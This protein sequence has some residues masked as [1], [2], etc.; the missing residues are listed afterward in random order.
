MFSLYVLLLLSETPLGRFSNFLC[1][2]VSNLLF[3]ILHCGK[4]FQLYPI[5]FLFLFQDQR[6]FFFFE[7]T[8]HGYSP[9]CFMNVTF[10]YASEMINSKICL[11]LS[12]ALCN[13]HFS[14]FLTFW[15]VPVVHVRDF[16]YMSAYPWSQLMFRSRQ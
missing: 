1:S 16:P 3:F 8:L 15:F 14:P 9:S 4:K 11:K 13:L 5:T 12:L 2:L 10:S 6:D 7:G